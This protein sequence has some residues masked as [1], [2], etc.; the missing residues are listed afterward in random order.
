M[1]AYLQRLLDNHPLKPLAIRCHPNEPSKRP[2]AEDVHEEM[3]RVLQLFA[4]L[5]SVS[6]RKFP[7]ISP[8]RILCRGSKTGRIFEHG[9]I[10]GHG[11]YFG[12]NL[13]KINVTH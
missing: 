2:T 4:G 10:V 7:L 1:P 13:Q 12:R 11:R 8:G 5:S 3:K 9:L 6:Y